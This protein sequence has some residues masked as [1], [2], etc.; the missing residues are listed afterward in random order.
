[1]V[2][3]RLGSVRRQLT[4]ALSRNRQQR[5]MRAAAATVEMLEQRTLLSLSVTGTLSGSSITEGS[6]VTLTVTAIPS[7]G[8][9]I[10]QSFTVDWADG[11]PQ[12]TF[13][14]D[15]VT[16]QYNSNQLDATVFPTHTYTEPSSG[17][18]GDQM[19]VWTN[20][21]NSDGSTDTSCS[22]FSETVSEATPTVNVGGSGVA[23]QGS[24]YT[25]NPGFNDPGGDPVTQWQFTWGDGHSEVDGP[26]GSYSHV[27]STAGSFS[28]TAI[29]T[30]EDGQF[31]A[32][33]PVNVS[34]PAPSA[35]TNFLASVSGS[36]VN[37]SWTASASGTV[38]AYHVAR[39]THGTSYTDVGTTG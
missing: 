13:S 33:Q 4:S 3:S 11:S 28:V 31:Q 14:T 10:D 39:S 19:A 7:P 12:Q 21:T 26:G 27:F 9:T 30:S 36:Q 8:S 17:R 25:I 2:W 22:F 23:T 38:T 1:M 6:T 20:E 29:A 24:T 18:F 15:W 5:L 32:T 37:T 35:P 16:D 34:G